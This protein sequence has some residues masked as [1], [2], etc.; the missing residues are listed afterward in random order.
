MEN[1]CGNSKNRKHALTKTLS[2]DRISRNAAIKPIGLRKCTMYIYQYT[3]AD[4]QQ[5]QHDDSNI[6]PS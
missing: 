6:G 1:K 4:T 2:A 5:S 3:T